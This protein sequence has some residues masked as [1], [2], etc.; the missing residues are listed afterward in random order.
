MNEREIFSRA[1]E[2]EDGAERAASVHAACG[3]DA[4]LRGRV[5]RLLRE[6]SRKSQ[7]ILDRSPVD[8]QSI[9]DLPAISEKIGATLGPFKLI[10]QIGEGGMGV[11][12]IAEQREPIRRRVALK[13]IKP[14]LDTKEVMAR[15]AAERQALAMMDHPH[16]ARAL[17]AGVTET[18]RPY[19]VMELVRGIPIT[20][21][22]DQNKLG[23]KQRL[24]L[25][26]D[27]CHAI[28]HAHQKGIIHRDIKPGNVLVAS[29]DGESLVKVIDFGVA[30]AIDQQFTEQTICTQFSQIVGTPLYMS[31]EQVEMGAVDV[32][33]RTDIYS[34]GVML[35]E[36]LTGQP[37][38]DPQRLRQATYDEMRCMIREEEPEK[39]SVKVSTLGQATLT[40]SRDR[41]TESRKLSQ[42]L[43]GDLNWIVMKAL[44]KDRE[45]R[46][47]TASSFAAD[48]GRYLNGEAVVA[49]PPSVSYRLQKIVRRNK[50]PVLAASLLLMTLLLGIAG[51]TYG[52]LR[53]EAARQDAVTA[54]RAEA[55]R[56]EGERLAKLAAEAQKD[57]A[58]EATAYAKAANQKAQKRLS[59]IEKAN[60]ILGS[61]FVGLD[62][63]EIARADRPLQAMLVEKLD[64]AV[65]QIEGDAI[66]DPLVVASIQNKLGTSLLALGAPNRAALLFEK[67]S[68]T[69]QAKLGT[70][71]PDTLASMHNLATAYM[72][73]GKLD[74]AMPLLEETLKLR[75]A[76]LGPNHP[77]M[78]SSMHSLAMAYEKAGKLDLAM[79][80]WEETLKLMQAKLGPN[81]P[82]T[83]SSMNNLATAYMKT[84]KLDLAMPLWEETLKLMQAKL[85]PNHPH[86]LASMNNLAI[87]YMKAGKLDLAMPLWEET[88]KL[89]QAKLGP[90]H[91]HTLA[92]MDNLATAY[93]EAGKLDLGI[94]LLKETLKLRQAKLGPDH[95][96]TLASMSNLA[97][98]CMKTGKLDLAMPLL[99]ETLKLRQA[100]LGPNHPHTLASM[101]SLAAAHI[102]SGK[103][104]LAMPLLEETLKL[105][106]TKLG[107]S[108]PHT[109]ASMNN[110]AVAYM[111]AEKLDLA[112][113]LLEETLKLRQAKLGPNHP[114]TLA[115]MKLREELEQLA[116][117]YEENGKP[118][119]A[120]RCRAVLESLKPSK[121]DSD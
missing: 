68:V 59:Q 3:N 19:F 14:G 43:R 102:E 33:T 66:G 11:V 56:A 113:P 37:P 60:D 20:D 89:M 61:I 86:T 46:Y 57:R 78:L 10:E 94:P 7:F 99:E 17:D 69:R 118:E 18:G 98:A 73:A 16:I 22:C 90:N 97:I 75:Q 106:Q 12:Y 70:D 65:A 24:R 119:E 83:L 87:A 28:Q 107:P 77:G 13:I 93:M 117:I 108:H 21:F 114:D 38:L 6:H 42:L 111:K 63:R 5:E 49:A 41:D 54:Q 44:D 39:L 74:L 15:F 36:L 110:L 88:L 1:I 31:P 23:I 45:R 53:A 91:P 112:M 2:I 35:Y 121:E 71:H 72:E 58:Q 76:K 116:K 52:L 96:D 100:K 109:L 32:D 26:I 81:H 25:F 4:E 47:G 29:Q 30:K 55:Q 95:P 50:G 120:A 92:N 51:T 62:P 8:L 85:G 48:V 115:S 101:H 79:P 34:L 67:S 103:L 84:G 105:R 64:L 27:A 9:T 104:D 82:D 80:L 40:I